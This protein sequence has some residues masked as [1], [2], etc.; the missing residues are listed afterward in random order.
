[1]VSKSTPKMGDWGSL[2]VEEDGREAPPAP[3]AGAM[4]SS[5]P[6]LHDS[7]ANSGWVARLWFLSLVVRG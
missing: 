3:F 2:A 6:S 4:S 1:M 7:D 5:A